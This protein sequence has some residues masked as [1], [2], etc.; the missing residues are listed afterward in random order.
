MWTGL[1][2]PPNVPALTRKRQS[3]G[4][5]GP[6]SDGDCRVQRQVSEQGEEALLESHRARGLRGTTRT[7]R[8]LS[9][10]AASA[11]PSRHGAMNDLSRRAAR[12]RNSRKRGRKARLF[13]RTAARFRLEGSRKRGRAVRGGSAKADLRKAPVLATRFRF[14]AGS[15]VHATP[16]PSA[17]PDPGPS[18]GGNR[19]VSASIRGRAASVAVRTASASKG[20][21]KWRFTT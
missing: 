14:V 20:P 15:C 8:E 17:P 13:K 9:G 11:S 2:G 10:F 18:G 19:R 12:S 1:F 7:M 4:T 16:K 3:E 5:E 21:A 6:P